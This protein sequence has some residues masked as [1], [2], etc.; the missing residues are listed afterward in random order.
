MISNALNSRRWRHMFNALQRLYGI[1][2]DTAASI[3]KTLRIVHP[4]G[5]IADLLWQD[6]KGM[7]FGF[8]ANRAAMQLMASRSRHTLS[9]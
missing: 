1:D 9:R 7:P 2:A 4:Y 3:M 5:T 6:E 8:P